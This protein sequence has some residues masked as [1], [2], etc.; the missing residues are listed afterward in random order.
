MKRKIFTAL[1]F[2][3]AALNYLPA[4]SV[5]ITFRI[6]TGEVNTSAG[7]YVGSDWA[8]W[9]FRKISETYR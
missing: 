5:N 3:F 8:G 4:K 9:S 2:L 7:V 6:E 1:L